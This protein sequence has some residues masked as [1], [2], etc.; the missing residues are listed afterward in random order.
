[1]NYIHKLYYLTKKKINGSK[2]V[3][4]MYFLKSLQVNIDRYFFYILHQSF[5]FYKLPVMSVEIERE[6]FHLDYHYPKQVF[7]LHDL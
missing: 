3:I 1:M 6:T 5:D 7:Q 2:D 4:C